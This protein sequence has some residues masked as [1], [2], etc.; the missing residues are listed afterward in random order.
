MSKSARELK[1][2]DNFRNRV[3]TVDDKGKRIF[4]L[5]KIIKGKWYKYRTYFSWLLLA[6]LF[7]TPFISYNG[8]PLLLFNVLE[9]KFIIFGAVF[10]PQDFILFLLAVISLIIF[11]ILF[12]V[13]FGRLFCGWACPQTVFMEMVFRK[14][15]VWIEGNPVKQKR[16]RESPWN[17]EKIRKRTLKYTIFLAISFLVGNLLMAYIVGKDQT[18]EIVTSAPTENWAGFVIVIAFT[19]ITFFNFA[20]F[21]EQVCTVV[22]PYGRLQGVLLDNKSMVVAY[23]HERGE[24]RE[25]P[26]KQRTESA[27]DCIDCYAC[28]DVCPTGIDIRNGTQLECVNCTACIDACDD[29]MDKIHKPRGLVRFASE[30]DI[31]HK[32][33]TKFN[34]RA[35]AYSTVL[36]LILTL[37]SFLL[38]TRPEVQATIV[39]AKGSLYSVNEADMV[40]NIFNINVANKAYEEHQIELKLGSPWEG[41]ITY[42]GPQP[43]VAPES[44]ANGIFTLEIARKDL[45][46]KSMKIPLEVWSGDE[47][48]DE[49]EVNFLRP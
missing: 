44:T 12:T 11:V 33:K 9:R 36:V 16:L 3:S 48:L 37:F 40:K 26:K 32:K 6:L 4:I 43:L 10:W 27:G 23:D 13:V 49:V 28:V 18:L 47:L 29:I 31:Q 8:R 41:I 45:P 34:L 19:A 14:I 39:K 35:A 38:V 30:H 22:C 15:E 42:A 1:S 46:K 7:V 24:P 5:P 25:K 17:A 20:Y 2:Q 21:R